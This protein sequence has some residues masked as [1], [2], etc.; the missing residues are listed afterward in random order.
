MCGVF[1]G[2]EDAFTFW[3]SGHMSMLETLLICGF[4]KS[5]CGRVRCE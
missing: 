2:G 1:G 5:N 3:A 4:W